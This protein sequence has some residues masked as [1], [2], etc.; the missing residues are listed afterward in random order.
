SQT[1]GNLSR[2]VPEQWPFITIP[3]D[4]RYT[5]VKKTLLGGI[6]MLHDHQPDQ[7]QELMESLVKKGSESSS[8]SH[9]SEVKPPKPFEYPFD[10]DT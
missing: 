1:L 6:L 4:S 3:T 7:P 5:P 2:V 10:N 8:S 9:S